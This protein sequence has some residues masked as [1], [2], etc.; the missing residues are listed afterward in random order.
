MRDDELACGRKTGCFTSYTMPN[1]IFD[2]DAEGHNHE[3]IQ[4][5]KMF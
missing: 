3:L 1:A 5:E 2:D 4:T